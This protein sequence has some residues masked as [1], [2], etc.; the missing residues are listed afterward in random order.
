MTTIADAVQAE[1]LR[2]PAEVMRHYFGFPFRLL[3]PANANTDEVVYT[4][5]GMSVVPLGE[6][7]QG[8]EEVTAMFRRRHGIELTHWDL[9]V[10]LAEGGANASPRYRRLGRTRLHVCVGVVLIPPELCD[11]AT[12]K[13][14]TAVE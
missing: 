2:D 12:G 5:V 9:P 3:H 7:K 1:R 14:I 8:D 10:F 4:L 6:L 13:I 11:L